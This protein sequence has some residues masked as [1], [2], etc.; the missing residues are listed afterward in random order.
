M[1]RGTSIWRQGDLAIRLSMG[2]T[3]VTIW[4]IGV[5]YL[6]T[7]SPC[8]SKQY[9]GSGRCNEEN[10]SPHQPHDA[11][12]TA[13]HQFTK[14]PDPR[15]ITPITLLITLVIPINILLTKSP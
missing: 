1:F 5:I 12:T 10:H 6:P 7:K 2:I 11:P 15:L 13:Q 3:W 4:V 14:S 8:P 9:L